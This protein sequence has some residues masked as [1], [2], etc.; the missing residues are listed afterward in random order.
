M[1]IGIDFDNTI[2]SYEQVFYEIAQKDNININSYSLSG[3]YKTQVKIAL[4]KKVNGDI[5][6]QRIQGYVYGLGMSSAQIMFGFFNFVLN[7]RLN[8]WDVYIV[9][10]KSEY[11]HFDK[12]RT[13]LRRAALDWMNNNNF[14]YE[15]EPLIPQN[16]IF[17][18]DTQDLKIKKIIHLNLDFFIDDL[19]EVFQNPLFPEKINK[20]LLSKNSKNYDEGIRTFPSW[21][22]ISNE[23]FPKSEHESAILIFQWVCKKNVNK[24]ERVA[25]GGNS[26]VF[27]VTCND[28]VYA[29]KLYPEMQ[30]GGWRN[31]QNTEELACSF[32]SRQKI[33]APKIYT[34]DFRFNVCIFDWVD[35]E[36][37]SVATDK[38][39]E[40]ALHFLS[41]LND[42]KKEA[43]GLIKDASEACFS[44]QQLIDQVD[45]RIQWLNARKNNYLSSF[46][47]NEVFGTYG[48][49]KKKM[50]I[51]MSK[52]DLDQQLK[53]ELRI[54][55]PSDFGFHNAI[56]QNN[57]DVMFLDFEYFG[58]DDPAKLICDFL[59]HPGMNLSE[60][61]KRDWVLGAFKIYNN[62]EKL[63]ERVNSLWAMYGVRWILIILK[64]VKVMK[65]Q[66]NNFDFAKELD[67]MNI[68][69]AVQIEKAQK[70]IRHI[71][72]NQSGCPYV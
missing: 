65:H 17:F 1:R 11:G 18:L 38:D 52:L 37:I 68:E 25:G 69:N 39:L 66:D 44:P 5:Q 43:F 72:N 26:R 31:R 49:V 36:K 59:W 53:E 40:A 51:G 6:W 54:L 61:M 41:E 55:S 8:N 19:L 7:C 33:K 60:E 14:F 3:G 58:F 62:D 64:R 16:N 2:V 24:I 56:R 27:K 13:Q 28:A 4:A 34:S 10:H 9:S 50:L 30:N 29:M 12:S 15:S 57:N 23:L 48:I 71:K 47:S 22:Q 45:N 20:F 46:L 70:I 42:K 35:G 32:L 21:G 67:L 63:S